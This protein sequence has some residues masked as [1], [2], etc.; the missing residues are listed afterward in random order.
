MIKNEVSHPK[1]EVNFSWEVI[2]TVN[3]PPFKFETE[4]NNRLKRDFNEIISLLVDYEKILK[5]NLD[6]YHDF[7][8]NGGFLFDPLK[9]IG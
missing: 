4:M 8:V 5:R 3:Y 6:G 9:Y 7:P 1:S 2:F